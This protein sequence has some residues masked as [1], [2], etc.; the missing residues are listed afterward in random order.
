M[1]RLVATLSKV[2]HESQWVMLLQDKYSLYL[3]REMSPFWEAANWAAI[4]K[5]P[6]NFKQPEGSSPCPQEPSTGPYPEPDRSSPYHTIPFYLCKIHFFN[7]VHL[8][9]SLS[10]Y[11][12]LSF[13]LSHQYPIPIRPH[14]CY[15]PCPSHPSWL[16]HSNYV[17]RWVQVMK[18]LIMQFPPVSRHFIP[19]RSKYS[20][21]RPVM[22]NISN[23]MC[24]FLFQRLSVTH[25]AT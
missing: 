6:S 21:Q 11:W 4:Q 5:I 14:L 9:T 17:W 1:T 18:L 10:S 12:S 13:W 19:P 15:M 16:D 23:M 7:I 25:Q 3:L 22:H 8:P 20:P 2:P 24:T